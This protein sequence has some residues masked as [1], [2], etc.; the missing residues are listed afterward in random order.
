VTVLAQS[1]GT[2]Q[3]RGKIGFWAANFAS[4]GVNILDIL[5]DTAVETSVASRSAFSFASNRLQMSNNAGAWSPVATLADIGPVAS[6]LISQDVVSASQDL[7]TATTFTVVPTVARNFLPI[8]AYVEFTSVTALATGPTIKLGNNVAHDN[9]A[10][11]LAVANTVV[12]GS[13]PP[14]V[15]ASDVVVIDQTSTGI[16]GDV[17]VNAVGTTCTGRVHVIGVY[18]T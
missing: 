17:T 14:F 12:T 4:G 13:A 5:P 15:M 11:A 18:I 8:A 1:F 2:D 6:P 9:V 3:A 7:K 16:I 10:P